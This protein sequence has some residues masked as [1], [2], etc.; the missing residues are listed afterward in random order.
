[1]AVL[2]LLEAQLGKSRRKV[3]S[4]QIEPLGAVVKF[5]QFH[6]SAFHVRHF[7][8]GAAIFELTPRLLKAEGVLS[9]D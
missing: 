5:R 6:P 8:D 3:E 7:S 9:S 4:G 1:L 2:P